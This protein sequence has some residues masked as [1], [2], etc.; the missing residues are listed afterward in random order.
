MMELPR[1]T[2]LWNQTLPPGADL[3]FSADG[4]TLYVYA[5]THSEMRAYESS[6]GTL[7]TTFVLPGDAKDL[8]PSVTKTTDGRFLLIHRSVG[9]MGPA[10]WWS[11]LPGVGRL[12]RRERNDTVLVLDMNRRRERFRLH[13][14]NTS[15][16]LLSDDGRTLVTAHF[17]N[18]RRV[19]R[20]WDVDA[21]K[22]LHLPIGVPAGLG[23]VVVLLLWWRGR[24]AMVKNT[25]GG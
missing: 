13:G 14:W 24:L 2:P 16:S 6:T 23:A 3:L 15:S 5:L 19:L 18:D 1:A 12:L 10:P 11:K 21:W 8:E 9:G 22:P 17:E 25:A 7:R 4:E 20:C